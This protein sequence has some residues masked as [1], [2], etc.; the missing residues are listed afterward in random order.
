MQ[1][2]GGG[3]FGRTDAG[4]CWGPGGE[5]PD[6]A[7]SIA[8]DLAALHTVFAETR[9]GTSTNDGAVCPEGGTPVT[10]GDLSRELHIGAGQVLRAA[11]ALN[12]NAKDP[13]FSLNLTDER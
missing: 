2:P 10:V 13:T 6:H 5:G 4:A 12:I 1:A 3:V 11:R 9:G 8:A 7:S